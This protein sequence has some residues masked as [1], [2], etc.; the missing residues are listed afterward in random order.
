MVVT[1]DVVAVDVGLDGHDRKPVPSAP[2]S[3]GWSAK[4]N[5]IADPTR[6]AVDGP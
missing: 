3:T 1:L 4:V 6:H 5:R 2:I